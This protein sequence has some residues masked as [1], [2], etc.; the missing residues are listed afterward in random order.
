MEITH[1][2]EFA[3]QAVTR[4]IRK[5]TNQLKA[6]NLALTLRSVWWLLL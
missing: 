1:K 6:V 3:D 2:K 5:E 4:A